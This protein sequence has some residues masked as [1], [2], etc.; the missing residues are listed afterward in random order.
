VAGR[1][2]AEVEDP[3]DGLGAL[4]AED[5]AIDGEGGEHEI[6]AGAVAAIATKVSM[7]ASLNEKPFAIALLRKSSAHR[8]SASFAN[9]SSG[10]GDP[11][12]RYEQQWTLKLVSKLPSP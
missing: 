3:V 7:S 4:S 11:A 10:G 9:I 6:N 2:V 12:Q 1:A 5:R 8:G